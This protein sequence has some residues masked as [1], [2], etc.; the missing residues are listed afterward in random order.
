MAGSADQRSFEVRPVDAMCFDDLAVILN[1]GGTERACWCLAHRVTPAE[2]SALRGEQRAERTRSLCAERPA[3]GVLAYAGDTPAGWCGV[4]PRSRFERLKRSRTIPAL[5]DQPVWSIVCFVVASPFRGLGVAKALLDGAVGYARSHDAP[6]VEG[7]PVDT[8]GARIG[9]SAAHAGTTAL[10]EEA[11]FHR[12]ER[13]QARV[14]GRIRWLMRLD[15][16]RSEL[17]DR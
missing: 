5:D 3:P 4:S 16:S 6:A 15:L 10:F 7:Y 12:M 13:T 11:G 17:R 8:E 9:P 14:D 2:Y 1:P